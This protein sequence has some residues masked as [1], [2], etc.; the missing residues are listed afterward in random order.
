M[1]KPT[2]ASS[3]ITLSQAN[4]FTFVILPSDKFKLSA[5]KFPHLSASY[6]LIDTLPAVF[7]SSV[8]HATNAN[9][10]SLSSHNKPL[11]ITFVFTLSPRVKIIPKS[12]LGV[13][14]SP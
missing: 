10:S 6:P 7:P 9:I 1:F 13:S 11:F 2:V 5:V 12:L 4:E 14:V 3:T 8:L